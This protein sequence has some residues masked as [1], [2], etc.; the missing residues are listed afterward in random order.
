MYKFSGNISWT[1]RVPRTFLEWLAAGR[2]DGGAAYKSGAVSCLLHLPV[3]WWAPPGAAVVLSGCG[4]GTTDPKRY[5][6]GCDFKCR[7]RSLRHHTLWGWST[8]SSLLL[9]LYRPVM[10]LFY[11][12]QAETLLST[13]QEEVEGLIG[14]KHTGSPR[15]PH[16]ERKFK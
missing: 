11:L 14:H 7:R 16:H 3:W 5:K 15:V 1:T 8:R 12:L 2:T 4:A 13:S 9:L 10:C 6:C